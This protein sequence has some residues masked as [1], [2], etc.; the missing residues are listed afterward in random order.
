MVTS[1]CVCVCV[2]V[3]NVV[4]FILFFFFFFS[5]YLYGNRWVLKYVSLQHE[6]GLND[7][8]GKN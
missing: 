7:S 1:V 3:K 4:S 2:C 6:L 8:P 5:F